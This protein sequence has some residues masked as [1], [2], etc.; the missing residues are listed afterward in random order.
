MLAPLHTTLRIDRCNM[1][2]STPQFELII[3]LNNR[4][5]NNTTSRM[6]LVKDSITD[7]DILIEEI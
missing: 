2:L 1:Y 7:G 4:K 5:L 3:F 6:V